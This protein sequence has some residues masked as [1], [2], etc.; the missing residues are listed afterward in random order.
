MMSAN[1]SE[2][3][4][5]PGA[6]MIHQL[7][8]GAPRP[9]SQG[10]QEAMSVLFP[11]LGSM[12]S[13]STARMNAARNFALDGN[14]LGR[15]EA[16][17]AAQQTT[18]AMNSTINT[19]T[20]GSPLRRGSVNTIS[21]PQGTMTGGVSFAT[22]TMGTP[23]KRGKDGHGFTKGALNMYDYLY[24]YII[25]SVMLYICFLFFIVVNDVYLFVLL[26]YDIIIIR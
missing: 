1:P 20:T 24:L 21:T 11:T 23:A 5:S 18:A 26:N 25:L 16:I 13:K 12:R 2:R 19:T 3:A 10:T 8:E 14:D 6:G 15:D 7:E 22:G 9:P 17:L 4:I